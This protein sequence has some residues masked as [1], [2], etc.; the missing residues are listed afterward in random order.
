MKLPNLKKESLNFYA[1][2]GKDE[3][4]PMFVKICKVSQMKYKLKNR[5]DII[6]K[7]KENGGRDFSHYTPGISCNKI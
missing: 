6:K 1:D 7:Y 5:W 3:K 4:M 2:I